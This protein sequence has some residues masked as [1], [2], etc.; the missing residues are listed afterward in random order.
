M[1]VTVAGIVGSFLLP[2]LA[3]RLPLRPL[4]LWIGVAGSIMTLVLILLSRTA[5]TFALAMLAENAFQS[6]AIACS[7]AIYFETSGQNNPLA[8]TNFALLSLLTTFPI[9]Y[10]VVDG[11]GYGL[12]RVK[13]VPFVP[14]IF[15]PIKPSFSRFDRR[16][17]TRRLPGITWHTSGI[18]SPRGWRAAVT[19]L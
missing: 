11:W 13:G 7:T 2:G 6:L 19:I 1:G 17:H 12:G 16:A 8:A 10:M 5:P 18:R 4:Y 14:V 3:R 15:T 9:S